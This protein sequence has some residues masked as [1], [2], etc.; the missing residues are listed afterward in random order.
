MVDVWIMK[1]KIIFR[2]IKKAAPKGTA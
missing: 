2:K 1:M